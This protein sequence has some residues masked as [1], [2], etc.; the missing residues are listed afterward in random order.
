MDC[1][2]Y[3]C[4]DDNHFLNFALVFCR[5]IFKLKKVKILDLKTRYNVNFFLSDVSRRSNYIIF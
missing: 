1:L 4:V 2:F 5:E 3:I